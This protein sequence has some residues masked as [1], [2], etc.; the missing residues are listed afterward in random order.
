MLEFG[1]KFFPALAVAQ[2]Q[3]SP[4]YRGPVY[5]IPAFL[6]SGCMDFSLCFQLPDVIQTDLQSG[7][8]R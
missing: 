5:Y 2:N 4:R 6:S 8:S 7:Q 1:A 3:K